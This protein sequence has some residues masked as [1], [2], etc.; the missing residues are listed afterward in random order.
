MNTLYLKYEKPRY[1]SEQHPDLVAYTDPECTQDLFRW[2]G[3]CKPK[4]P[5]RTQKTYT[6]MWRRYKLVWIDGDRL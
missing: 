1:W 2:V 5:P 4:V 6:H 3:F